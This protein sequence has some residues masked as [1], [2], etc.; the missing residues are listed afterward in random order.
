MPVW[1]VGIVGA[2]LILYDSADLS[3]NVENLTNTKYKYHAS[4]VWGAGTN[5]ILSA[6]IHY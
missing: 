5:A 6:D 4:G 2:G 1:T 3:L